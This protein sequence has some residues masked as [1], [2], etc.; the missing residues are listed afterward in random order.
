MLC[1]V[2]HAM[3]I[4][5][6]IVYLDEFWQ[7]YLSQIAFPVVLFGLISAAL[8]A[9]RI[10][11]AI[12]TARLLQCFRPKTLMLLA[13]LAAAAG[14]VFS[15]LTHNPAGFSGIVMACFA[16]EIIDMTASGYLHHRAEP[17]IRATL[18]STG[19]LIQRGLSIGIGLVF[20]YFSS[21]ISIFLRV[22]PFRADLPARNRRVCPVRH[23]NR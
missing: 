2:V 3:L 6:C 23:S 15:A 10:A 5:A 4:A 8:T 12:L 13:S 1:V 20:G 7:L 17:D 21:R 14:I 16:A 11:G 18:D 22:F 9:A 19:A